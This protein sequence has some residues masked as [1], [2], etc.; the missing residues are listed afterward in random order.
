MKNDLNLYETQLA[1]SLKTATWAQQNLATERQRL[2][3]GAAPKQFL[4]RAEAN[5]EIRAAIRNA[6]KHYREYFPEIIEAMRC[7]IA[8]KSGDLFANLRGAR[9]FDFNN[10]ESRAKFAWIDTIAKAEAIV[11]AKK[12]DAESGDVPAVRS[13]KVAGGEIVE[14]STVA[15]AR[16]IIAA[17]RKRRGED[18]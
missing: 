11:R 4:T 2:G 1:N 15:K 10:P 6:Q 14:L 12:A 13:A 17:G 5:S 9:A 7:T 8:P 18:E 3:L 16:A